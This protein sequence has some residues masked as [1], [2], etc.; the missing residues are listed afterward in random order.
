M[1][2][3]LAVSDLI[4]SLSGLAYNPTQAQ[5]IAAAAVEK[6]L[7]GEIALVDAN[8]PFVL[9]L[10]V[11]AVNTTHFLQQANV[12]TRK[13]YPAAATTTRDLYSHLS[14][15]DYLNLFALPST[16][17]FSIWLNKDEVLANMVEDTATGVSKITIPRNTKFF[18]AGTPFSL[19]YPISIRKLQHGAIQIVYDASVVSPLQTLETNVITYV[20]RTTPEGVTY[21]TFDVDAMQFEITTTNASVSASSGIVSAIAINQ[22]YYYCRVWRRVSNA[23]VEMATTYTQQVYDPNTPTAVLQVADGILTVAIPPVYTITNQVTGKIRIDLYE[24]KGPL[25]QYFGNL[26][27]PDFSATWLAIDAAEQTA[28]VAAV[29]KLTNVLVFSSDTTSGGRNALTFAEMRSRVIE[30]AVGPRKVPITPAQAK[31]MLNDDGY[32]VVVG[33]DSV[34][35]RRFV[36]SRALPLPKEIFPSVQNDVFTAA[37]AHILT[38]QLRVS[39][40]ASRHGCVSHDLGMTVTS[41]ALF[42]TNNG[43]SELVT[44]TAYNLL[45]SKS[46]QLFVDEINAGS[47]FYTPFHYVLDA[48]E[49][50]FDARVYAMDWPKVSYRTFVQEN[51]TSGLQVSIGSTYTVEKVTSGYRIRITTTSNDA[52]KA[53]AD[54]LVNCQLRL[55]CKDGQYAYMLGTQIA[56]S[57]ASSERVFVFDLATSYAIDSTH[58]LDVSTAVREDALPVRL[59]GLDISAQFLFTTS[60]TLP[61]TFTSNAIDAL[62]GD[63]QLPQGSVGIT[64]EGLGLTLGT[65]LSSLWLDFRSYADSIEYKTWLTDQVATYEED[66]YEVNPI[67]GAFFNVVNGALQ[68]NKLHSAGD[69]KLDSDGNPI[70]AHRAGDYQLDSTGRPIP[71]DSYITRMLRE[72]DFYVVDAAYRFANDSIT[73][74]YIA[75]A[76]KKL[77]TQLTYDL[78][79]LNDSALEQTSILYHPTICDGE[80]EVYIEKDATVVIDSAQQFDLRIYVPS[81]TNSNATLTTSLRSTAIRLIGEYLASNTTVSVDALESLLRTSFGSDAISVKISG[82][83]GSGDYRVVTVKN[84]AA[85]LSIAKSL[86][87]K[88]NNLLGMEEAVSVTFITHDTQ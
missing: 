27:L 88:V 59:K 43:I 69:Q 66:V 30:N 44:S 68:Y 6:M 28:D 7:S 72:V 9:A 15:T 63:F 2:K 14:D 37:S 8:N 18:A 26:Q 23:W 74:Q 73:T 80:I 39:D 47:Y 12:L 33:V 85:R 86:V 67:T 11:S 20:E 52:Y 61:V 79:A 13:L 45:T 77:L 46:A 5:A 81:E 62:L 83:G 16:A 19:N 24:T 35:D 17:K 56:R 22:Q 10:E 65:H 50:V 49:E 25:N 70:Y 3:S 1:A 57:N 64:H 31:V 40:A 34:T 84:P 4:S 54:D 58:T 32:T 78:P 42:S 53:L 48:S 71:V 21:L 55:P 82:L 60:A 75:A 41:S 51:A 76:Y 38:S 36:A 87:V 29:S